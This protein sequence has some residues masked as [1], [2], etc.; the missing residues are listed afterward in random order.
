M[1]GKLAHTSL[2]PTDVAGPAW[3]EFAAAGFG[4]PVFGVIYRDGS[5]ER[6]VPLGGLGTGFIALGTDGTLDHYSTIFNAFMERHCVALE[7]SGR[8]FT[9]SRSDIPSLRLPFLGLTIGGE[10]HL[11]SLEA[12]AGVRTAKQIHYW[13]HYPVADLQYEIDAPLDVGLRA[14]T[15]FYPGDAPESNV[16]GAVFEVRLANPSETEQ[17]GTLAF[18]FGG[19]RR[20]ELAFNAHGPRQPVGRQTEYVRRRVEGEFTGVVVDTTWED[21]TYGYALGVIGGRQV[22]VGGELVG[23]QWSG[24]ADALPDPAPT[25]PGASVAVDFCLAPGAIETVRFVLSWYAPRCRSTNRRMHRTH[26]DYVHVYASC[27]GG[28]EDVARRLALQ[29][30]SLLRRILSWQEAIYA[31]ERLPGW[32][33]DALINVFAVLPQQS[34]WL[35]SIDPHHWWGEEGL[36]CV[37]ESLLSCPQQ[38]CIANDEFGEWPVNIFF[39]DLALNKL[40][41]FKRYQRTNGQVPSTLGSGTEPDQPWYDQQLPIDGQVYVHMV[42]RYWQVTG[43]ESVLEEFYASVKAQT[44]FMKSVDQDGD[45]LVDVKGSNQYYDNWP[46]MAG[47][48]THVA[49]YWL[50]TLRIAERMAEE[51]GDH[52]FAADCRGWCERGGRSIEEKLWNEEEGSYLLYHEPETGKRSESILSDQL[53]GQWFA[54]LHGLERVFPEDRVRRVLDT[55]WRNNLTPYGV[56]IALRPDGSEDQEG[57]YSVGLHPSYSSHVPAMLMIYGGDRAR[58]EEIMHRIWRQVVIG[59]QMPWDMPGGLAADGQH[60][61]GLEYYHNTMLWTLPMAFLGHTLGS[62]CAPGELVDRV[63]R[64]GS[65]R[66]SE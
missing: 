52:A 38:A 46:T 32:T 54:H 18:S 36:F 11:L 29:H 57:F 17:P 65:G 62:F 37:N 31:E 64:A 9:H 44:G 27:F 51:M 23:T 6:G 40:R 53:T 42:D 20:E 59:L 19:P 47:A 50:A 28:A 58:G 48:A 1:T 22:R 33:R 56:R 45:A 66:A 3:M 8:D 13:G 55:I 25:D 63:K 61:W 39:P 21:L 16:P 60:R 43:D 4:Q 24:L 15:P 7:Q 30:D 49:G 10:T 14:W 26:N 2:F 34:F 5:A 12:T 35:R 41:Q